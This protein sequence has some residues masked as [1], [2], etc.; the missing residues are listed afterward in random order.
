MHKVLNQHRPR[1]RNNISDRFGYS[2]PLIIVCLAISKDS[3]QNLCF[4]LGFSSTFVQIDYFI[5]SLQQFVEILG[6]QELTKTRSHLD[7]IQPEDSW[8]L[9]Y[10]QPDGSSSSTG[11]LIFFEQMIYFLNQMIR[12]QPGD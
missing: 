11:G 2:Q 9:N 10:F 6:T 5:S 1:D 3:P 7:V 12:F 8:M 4:V